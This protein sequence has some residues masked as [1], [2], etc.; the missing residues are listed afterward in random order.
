MED[1][2]ARHLNTMNINAY[3]IVE[4]ITRLLLFTTSL[5]WLNM[6]EEVPWMYI[7]PRKII[8]ARIL[9]LFK[10]PQETVGYHKKKSSGIGHLRHAECYSIS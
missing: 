2:R 1:A 3:I 10:R 9:N 7:W 4:I 8:F 6:Q 5:L